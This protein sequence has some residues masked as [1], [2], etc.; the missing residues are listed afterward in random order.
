MLAVAVAVPVVNNPPLFFETALDYFLGLM[1]V[2]ID[3]LWLLLGMMLAHF[4]EPFVDYC[5]RTGASGHSFLGLLLAV[6]VVAY[7]LQLM[8]NLPTQ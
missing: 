3:K 5:V 2:V 4:S 8:M 7:D 6:V 1:S